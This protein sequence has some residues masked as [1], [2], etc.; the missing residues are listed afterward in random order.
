MWISVDLKAVI[1]SLFKYL[2]IGS[3]ALVNLILAEKVGPSQLGLLMPVLIFITYSNYSIFGAPQ[4]ILKYLPRKHSNSSKERLLG[5]SSKL[6]SVGFL[7]TLI[8]A[9]TFLELQYVGLVFYICIATFISSFISSKLRVD[10][11]FTPINTANFLSSFG[12]LALTFYYVQ[13]INTYLLA[14]AFAKSCMLLVYVFSDFK[15]FLKSFMSIWKGVEFKVFYF[16]GRASLTMALSGL[17]F[18]LLMSI[19]RLIIQSWGLHPIDL[20][21]YQLADTIGMAF[22]LGVTTLLFYFYPLFLK[23]INEDKLFRRNYLKGLMCL[24]VVPF[25]SYYPSKFILGLLDGVI[26]GDYP[27]VWILVP[28]IIVLKLVLI[29]YS[30]LLTY[31][32]SISKDMIGVLITICLC[33]S[34]FIINYILIPSNQ[35]S[36]AFL[37]IVYSLIIFVFIFGVFFNEYK[38]Q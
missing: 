24:S 7:I 13:D 37:P 18:T 10:F 15:F 34:I 3:L 25:I 17:A 16:Y 32:I 4:L 1:Y 19:D 2:E 9:F 35:S 27:G 22:Y 36:L 20:G 12:L 38:K 6:L 29:A 31:F 14:L 8:V 28:K 30:S 26:F 11:R 5:S 23:K 33:L 21:V